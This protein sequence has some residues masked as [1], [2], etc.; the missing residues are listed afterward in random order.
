MNVSSWLEA[1]K[2]Y[3]PVISAVRNTQ[4]ANVGSSGGGCNAGLAGLALLSAVVCL[5]KKFVSVRI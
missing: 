2:V 1:G 4:N 5:R 3:M